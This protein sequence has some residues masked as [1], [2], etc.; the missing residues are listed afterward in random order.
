MVWVS[1]VDSL[2]Q[3]SFVLALLSLNSVL[4]GFSVS[5]IALCPLRCL[6]LARFG[7]LRWPSTVLARW[8]IVE[9]ASSINFP[10]T[11]DTH[12]YSNGHPVGTK[13]DFNLNNIIASLSL[14]S[15]SSVK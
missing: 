13:T 5:L 2:L 9:L 14:I 1:L 7:T 10:L 8:P 4:K 3:L 11:M 12:F 15:I 6:D